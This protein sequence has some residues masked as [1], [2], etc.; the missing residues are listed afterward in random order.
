MSDDLYFTL[1]SIGLCLG[2]FLLILLWKGMNK[3]CDEPAEVNVTITFEF[4]NVDDEK[5]N[6]KG[7]SE[8]LLTENKE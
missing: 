4:K 7:D 5:N 1:Y 3:L 6:H 2:V 8:K